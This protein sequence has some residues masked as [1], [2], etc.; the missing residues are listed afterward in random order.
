MK[1]YTRPTPDILKNI[2]IEATA[3]E[4]YPKKLLDVFIYHLVSGTCQEIKN[5]EKGCRAYISHDYVNI[6]RV[7]DDLLSKMEEGLNQDEINSGSDLAIAHLFNTVPNIQDRWDRVYTE[8]ISEVVYDRNQIVIEELFNHTANEHK[9]PIQVNCAM[10]EDS[11]P[12]KL[13]EHLTMTTVDIESKKDMT[14]DEIINLLLE[15]KE[16]YNQEAYLKAEV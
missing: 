4:K 5:T 7:A 3:E 12:L 15:L 6:V 13:V 10:G 8:D 14:F 9:F 1:N 2:A 16:S 11:T